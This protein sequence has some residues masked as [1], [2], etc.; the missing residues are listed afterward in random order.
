MGAFLT[1]GAKWHK[2]MSKMKVAPDE[3][4]KTKDQKKCSGRVI[5]NKRVSHFLV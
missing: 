5:E 2:K 1:A 4:L 3:L